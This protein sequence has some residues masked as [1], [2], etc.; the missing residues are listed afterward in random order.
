MNQAGDK[1]TRDHGLLQ[2][3]GQ[4]ARERDVLADPRW[5]ALAAGKL[6]PADVA[7]LRAWADEVPAARAVFDAMQPIDDDA[8]DAMTDAALRS[9]TRRAPQRAA[10]PASVPRTRRAV[11]IVSF[12][13]AL[14]AAA[15]VLLILRAPTPAPLGDYE[16]V[17]G[18]GDA[19]GRSVSFPG[20]APRFAPGSHF[21]LIARPREPVAGPLAARAALVRNGRSEVWAAPAHIIKGGAVQIEGTR[22]AV[23]PGIPD[24]DVEI[25]LAIG[26]PGE[27]PATLPPE[28]SFASNRAIRVL[29]TRIVLASDIR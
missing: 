19:N 18:P 2:R 25:W 3:L 11:L 24:G 14:A 5:E 21:E 4:A 8:L 7:E 27:L 1:P 17:I 20:G 10:R 16:L 23:F 13:G 15:A 29:H 6:S 22:E 28:P 9:S 26:R 12:G